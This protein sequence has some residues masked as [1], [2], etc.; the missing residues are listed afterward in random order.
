MHLGSSFYSHMSSPL[1]FVK[2]LWREESR[3]WRRGVGKGVRQL[4]ENGMTTRGARDGTDERRRVWNTVFL[5]GF[6]L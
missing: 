4:S 2:E 6:C 3:A 5:E 1:P